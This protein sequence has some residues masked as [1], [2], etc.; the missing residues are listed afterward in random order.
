MSADY[1]EDLKEEICTQLLIGKENGEAELETMARIVWS[2][3]QTC[4]SSIISEQLRQ[5]A[6]AALVVEETVT[7]SIDQE[8]EGSLPKGKL[9]TWR[10]SSSSF[11]THVRAKLLAMTGY[12]AMRS[13]SMAL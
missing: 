5:A 4:V 6:V 11:S 2:E 3:R 7:S 9:Q 1:W 13:A 8:C 12:V 10:C